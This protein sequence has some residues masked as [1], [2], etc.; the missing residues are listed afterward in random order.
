M[1]RLFQKPSRIRG[2]LVP[3]RRFTR[4]A[5]FYFVIFVA[6]P[7]LGL[8]VLLDLIAWFITTNIFEASCYGIACF[9]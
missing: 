8:A 1:M 4:Q 6:L 3:A 2:R 7:I 9:F 5:F